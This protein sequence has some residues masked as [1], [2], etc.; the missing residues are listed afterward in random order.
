MA[1]RIGIAAE[2]ADPL[3]QLSVTPLARSQGAQRE[4]GS[5]IVALGL[6]LR[7]FD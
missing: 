3:G 1:S 4:A 5:L 7:N 6:A 2:K